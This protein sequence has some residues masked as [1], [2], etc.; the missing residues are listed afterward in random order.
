MFI[1]NTHIYIYIYIQEL[2]NGAA[3]AGASVQV[4][5][6][7]ADAH[8]AVAEACI[9]HYYTIYIHPILSTYM[10]TT[11]YSDISYCV[12]C[13]YATLHSSIR[14]DQAVHGALQAAGLGGS[15]K[16]TNGVSTNGVT[17]KCM[18]ADTGTIY[19]NLLFLRLCFSNLSKV[20]TSAATPLVLTP[21]VRHR[22]SC[23]ISY[24]PVLAMGPS[25]GKQARA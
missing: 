25:G 1:V 4:Q 19:Q 11:L 17:A 5:Y 23:A 24:M 14:Y 16:G 13:C 8:D 15:R 6:A 3:P 20:L 7:L 18:F 9:L 22:G 2:T 10:H 21:F 12:L